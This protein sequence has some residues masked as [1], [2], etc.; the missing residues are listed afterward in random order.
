M[1]EI[2]DLKRERHDNILF[3]LVAVKHS[4]KKEK[5]L[6]TKRRE[7]LEQQGL[8]KDAEKKARIGVMNLI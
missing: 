1:K 5:L 3:E 6:A 7:K 4:T 8:V 2:D